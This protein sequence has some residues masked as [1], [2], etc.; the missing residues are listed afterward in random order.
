[1]YAKMY[2]KLD[3]VYFIITQIRI[4]LKIN[5]MREHF[6]IFLHILACFDAPRYHP[7]AWMVSTRRA[8]NCRADAALS[9]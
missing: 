7:S 6:I 9:D 3:Q 1:M 2:T 5:G 8:E 4:L